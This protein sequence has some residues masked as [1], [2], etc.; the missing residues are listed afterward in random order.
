MEKQMFDFYKNALSGSIG[1]PL[2]A[3]YKN[4]WRA[5]GDDKLKLMGLVLRQQS[6]PYFHTFC[7]RGKGLTKEY[8]KREFKDYINGYIVHDAD[9]VDGYTYAMYIDWDFDNDI[10]L[11]VDVASVMW[12]KNAN[13]VIH[14]SKCPI[15]YIG[16]K[17]D[18]SISLDGYNSAR[19]YLFDESRVTISEADETCSVLV[20]K[21]SD[22]CVV[23]R[24]KYC[25]CEDINEFS[26]TLRL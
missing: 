16:N 3:D 14:T 10:E 25:L 21:F 23:E 5:C 2:C 20:Y 22:K 26:K 9:K 1:E 19:I 7:Y 24:G 8:C 6:I 15:L 18:V 11:N 12:T 17:S 4:E 13:I